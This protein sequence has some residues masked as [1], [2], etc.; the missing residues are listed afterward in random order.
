MDATLGVKNAAPSR[1]GSG[2]EPQ[3][4]GSSTP[5]RSRGTTRDGGKK[6]FPNDDERYEWELIQRFEHMDNRDRWVAADG[7]YSIGPPIPPGAKVFYGEKSIPTFEEATS[8]GY[9]AIRPACEILG[10]SR[11]GMRSLV[12]KLPVLDVAYVVYP[13]VKKNSRYHCRMIHRKSVNVLKRDV[14]KWMKEANQNGK[15][16]KAANIRRGG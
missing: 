9:V 1:Q 14:R 4:A 10:I 15:K 2:K 7:V 11:R 3:K 13:G 6:S 8:E 12:D 16:T 5:K